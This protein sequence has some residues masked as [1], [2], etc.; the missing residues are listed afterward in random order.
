MAD[1]FAKGLGIL[2]T[3]GLGWMVLA[4]WYNTAGFED[5]QLIAPDPENVEVYGQ[6]GL[7]LKD[8]LFWFALI[9]ALTFW[10]I[11]PAVDEA[12]EVWSERNS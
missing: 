12:R 2:M 11:I 1:E 5:T 3:A 6:L 8:A 4:G 7:L 9:G 10:V